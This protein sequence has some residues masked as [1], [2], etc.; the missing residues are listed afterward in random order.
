MKN[1]KALEKLALGNGWTKK[2]SGGSHRVY[3]KGNETVI[4]PIK[5]GKD[6]KKGT[7]IAIEKRLNQQ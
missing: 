2:R 7:S 6:M 3:K 4:I 5:N 1:S